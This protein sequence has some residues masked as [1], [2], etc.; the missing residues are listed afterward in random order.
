MPKG[1]KYRFSQTPAGRGVAAKTIQKRF[2]G[3]RQ[4]RRNKMM[5]RV[6]MNK[7]VIT[8]KHLWPGMNGI[9]P[10]GSD[11][12]DQGLINNQTFYTMF[13]LNLNRTNANAPA[14]DWADRE[15]SKIYAR[16]CTFQMR[17]KPDNLF[18][19][20]FYIRILAGYFKGDDNVGTQGLTNASLKSLYP[21]I[22]TG[23]YTK[24]T[25]QRD[26]YWKYQKRRLV[27]PKQI[28]DANGS[29]DADPIP[30]VPLSGEPMRALVC[31]FTMNYN[32]KF[33][34]IHEYEGGD[35]DSLQGWTP[36]IAVQ[37][38]PL[39]GNDP[40]Q[41]KTLEGDTTKPG[42]RPG[43]ILDIVATTYFNDCH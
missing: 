42:S 21:E 3:N 13:P 18:L 19:E 2:R 8:K 24:H 39:E 12:N 43:P 7:T 9:R 41:R 15:S 20:P 30:G 5:E 26:F 32:F 11:D 1:K 23:I 36:V 28:Y 4:R 14:N 17:V 29:D 22:D 33:N 6:V 34:R 25:G 10:F 31:P 35:G 16:N 38:L 40:F 27:C 37:C